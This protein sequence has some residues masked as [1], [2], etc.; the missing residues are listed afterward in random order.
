MA[1]TT[2][3]VLLVTPGFPPGGGG[4]EE[5]VGQLAAG[6]AARD[7]RVRVQS[8]R[9]GLRRR[10]AATQGGIVITTHP[11]WR[12]RIMSVSPR[13]ALAAWRA[14]H[15]ADLLH[16]HSYH[17]TT[18]LALFAQRPRAVVFTPH[19]HGGGHTRA[20]SVL[21]LGYRHLGRL[22]FRRADL[23]ICV[24]AAERD[25]VVADFPFVADRIRVIP[26]GVDVAAVR[27]A[28]PFPDQ[29]PT[30]LSLGRIEGYKRVDRLLHA[31]AAVPAPAQLVICGDGS[32]RT[33]LIQ[34]A[35]RLGLADRV[36]F[37]G[38]VDTEVVRRWLR[39][40]DVLVSLSEREA[41]GMVPME[42]AAAG[43][44]VVLSDIPAHR[45]IVEDHLGQ[46]ATLVP[47]GDPADAAPVAAAIRVALA[48]STRVEVDVPTWDEITER[49][50]AGYRAA[51]AHPRRGRTRLP[52][53]RPAAD[54][55]TSRHA[56]SG[57][58]PQPE[59]IS[60]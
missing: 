4:V 30:V 60:R 9:R 8:A 37:P 10:E 26:N 18:S 43:A 38:F 51:H 47:L 48:A 13:L 17:A 23:V 22:L 58:P 24:S 36:R 44:A 39:T 45:E 20:A 57:R 19:Y 49:T 25:L 32:H 31:F 34:L 35:A 50:L 56:G 6:L 3:D 29:P 5:H 40:A 7:V 21:H 42:A 11:A 16:V 15:R 28:A 1:D 41:F 52:I 33:D 2:P 55:T 46:R 12:L 53:E 14:G 54:R 59:E 27:A